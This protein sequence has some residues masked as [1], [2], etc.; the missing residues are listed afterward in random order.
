ML[1]SSAD[2]MPAKIPVETPQSHT[3]LPRESCLTRPPRSLLAPLPAPTGE[4]PVSFALT[5][6]KLF[7]N[8]MT[9]VQIPHPHLMYRP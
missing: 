7:S 3:A 9:P 6:F 2:L 1:S 5:N 4:V 8:M